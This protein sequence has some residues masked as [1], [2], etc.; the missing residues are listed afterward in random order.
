M[1]IKLTAPDGYTYL[2]KLTNRTH[3]TVI[4]DYSKRNRFELIAKQEG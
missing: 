4:I 2:D 1:M 3:K